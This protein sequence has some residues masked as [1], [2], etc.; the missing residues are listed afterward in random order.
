MQLIFSGKDRYTFHS[1]RW[2][3]GYNPDLCIVSKDHNGVSLHAQRSVLNNF[4]KSQ[5]RPVHIQIGIQIPLVKTIP[6]PK[7]DFR[8]VN[9]PAFSKSLDDNIRWIDTTVNNYERFI[10]MVKGTAKRYIPRG[11]RHKYI[12]CWNEESDRLYAEYQRNGQAETADKLLESLAKGRKDRWTETVERLDF[13]H[14]SREAWNV[15]R[16]LDPC[17]NRDGSEPEIKP[18]AFANRLIETSRAKIDKNISRK[19]TMDLKVK[20]TRAV[21][22]SQ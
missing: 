5:H 15:L 6:K 12:P 16:R 20:K 11:Y 10:G 9:W 13:K 21:E 18:N 17:Q 2:K 1:E 7:W 3:R 8:K 22:N 4:R 19:L 14:S